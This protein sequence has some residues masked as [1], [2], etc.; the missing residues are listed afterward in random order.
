M[1]R[2]KFLMVYP[3]QLGAVQEQLGISYLVA[4]LE[5]EGVDVGFWDGTFYEK[6]SFVQSVKEWKPDYVGISVRSN[7]YKS[8][9]QYANIAKSINKN[10][11]VVVGGVH[12]TLKPEDVLHNDVDA[13]IRGE[14]DE[15]LV[16]Y[17]KGNENVPGVITDDL[18]VERPRAPSVNRLALP[19]HGIWSI[20]HFEKEFHGRKGRLGMFLTSRGCP[21]NCSECCNAQLRRV[22]KGRWTRLRSVKSVAE[23]IWLSKEKFG[24]DHFY[25][26]DDTFTFNRDHVMRLCDKFKHIGLPWYCM[27][28]CDTVDL[29]MFEAMKEAGCETV[30][31]GIESGSKRIREE[32]LNR[33]MSDEEIIE[34]FGVAKKAGIK[35]VAFNMVGFPGET[36]E[37]FVATV[38]LN[39]AC[40]VDNAKM[41]ILTALPETRLWYKCKKEGL[42]KEGFP[43]N[44]YED[45]N[46]RLPGVSVK[47]LRKRQSFFYKVVRG[48]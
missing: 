36:F 45:T 14:A 35:T 15:T 46:I 21:F 7:D 11:K 13:I 19:N 18:E 41:T 8:G 27:A 17:V 22:H 31:M 10:I 20:R 39:L 4:Q 16:E 34:A 23:E 42:L 28:R 12:A 25:V 47:E 29:E 43:L 40:E 26:A 30:L 24:I 44:Y 37:D 9:L 1:V 6:S 48:A 33:K 38:R 3:N 5:R 2:I 32:V